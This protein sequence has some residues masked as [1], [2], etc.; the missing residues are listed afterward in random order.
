[1]AVMTLPQHAPPAAVRYE[2]FGRMMDAL[3]A[4]DALPG[5]RQLDWWPGLGNRE[6]HIEWHAGPYGFEVARTLRD[7]LLR[8]PEEAAC[9]ALRD[10]W[11][12]VFVTNPQNGHVRLTV[13]TMPIVLRALCPLGAV[14]LPGPSC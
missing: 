9:T 3:R 4:T 10:V 12:G 7:D 6:M 11:D 14:R 1:M 2:A 13:M 5:A 8:P